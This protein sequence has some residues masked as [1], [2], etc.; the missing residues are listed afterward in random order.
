MKFGAIVFLAAAVASPAAANS[1]L[2][3]I[4]TPPEGYVE[5]TL[6]VPVAERA[7]LWYDDRIQTV[8]PVVVSPLPKYLAWQRAQA[9]DNDFSIARDEL[10]N[11][12]YFISGAALAR[13][14]YDIWGPYHKHHLA[15]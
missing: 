3:M 2:K 1:Y 9:Y 10:Q 8:S 7:P 6:S 5:E 11:A 13:L 12:I 14:A 15:D 4:T